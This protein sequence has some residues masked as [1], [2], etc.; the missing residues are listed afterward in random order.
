MLPVLDLSSWAQVIFL[1]I[2]PSS[3][4]HK[5]MPLC[6]AKKNPF[7]IVFVCLFILF[8]FIF[9]EISVLLCHPG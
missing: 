9:F 7:I 1:L 8:Y 3:W 4:E 2:F 5:H 6:L